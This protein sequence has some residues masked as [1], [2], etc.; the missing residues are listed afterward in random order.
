MPTRTGSFPIGVR[1]GWSE[2][3]RDLAGMVKWAAGAGYEVMDLGP[4]SAAD[5]ELVRS[6]GLAVGSV[7]LI[8]MG[9][10]LQPDAGKRR[11]LVERNVA[12]VKAMSALGVKL[13]FT[14]MIPDPPMTRAEGHRVAV[15]AFG[16]VCAAAAESGGAVVFEGWPGPAP[17]YPAIACTP[18]S[19]RLLLRELGGTPG[20]IALNFDPSHLVRLGV[21][22]VRFLAEFA[23]SVRHAHGKDTMLYPEA[24]YELGRY[25]SS[26][27]R[28]PYGFGEYTWRYT[29]PGHGVV[30]WITCCKLL[31]QA[32][33]AGAVCVELEDE[34]FNGS[35][36]GEKEGLIYS[37]SYLRSV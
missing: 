33:Y 4:V 7:D 19:V 15:E 29:I 20:G 36:A 25:Q 1:R 30:D 8:D 28:K 35:E 10:M 24:V 37:L 26:A 6:G 14:V 11:E 21:D 12:H 23:P 27:E 13:F 5:V 2:W 9:K 32:G 17:V 34:S 16:P 18:E 31:K 3:Q 22:P